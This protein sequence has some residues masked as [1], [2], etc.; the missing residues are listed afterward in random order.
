MTKSKPIAKNLKVD[1]KLLNNFDHCI[2]DK[3]QL[4][5]LVGGYKKQLKLIKN[6]VVDKF[7][8]FNTS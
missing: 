8:N 6:Q 1:S 4:D 3:D 5:V 7:I 2:V